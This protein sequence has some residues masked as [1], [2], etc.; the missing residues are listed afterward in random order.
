MANEQNLKPIKTLSTEEAKK[1]GRNGGKRS[2]EVRRERKRLKEY[3]LLLLDL[4]VYDTK[5]FNKLS[6]MGVPVESIDNKMMLAAALF[7]KAVTQ[8]D[9]A[10]VKE[11]R[12]IIGDDMPEN[13]SGDL[14]RLIAGL[15]DGQGI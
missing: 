12:N 14:E 2:G 1:R 11:I 7:K 6:K 15:L 13:G 8:G 9:V 10:A 5:D 3:M 4:P